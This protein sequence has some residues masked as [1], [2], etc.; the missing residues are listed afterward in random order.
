VET[1]A[2]LLQLR[3]SYGA[4]HVLLDAGGSA[5]Q[6]DVD[7]TP[8]SQSALPFVFALP[9]HEH[10]CPGGGDLTVGV[11]LRTVAALGG[12]TASLLVRPGPRELDLDVL[13]ALALMLSRRL[14]IHVTADPS[15]DWDAALSRLLDDR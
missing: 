2:R 12:E 4:L 8:R 5:L 10:G 15:R 13:D 7:L 11:L 1:P 6:V 9:G 3:R 14:P